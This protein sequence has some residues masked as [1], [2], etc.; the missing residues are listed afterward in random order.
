MYK[1]TGPTPTYRAARS[2]PAQRTPLERRSEGLAL[3]RVVQQ[4]LAAGLDEEATYALVGGRLRDSFDAQTHVLEE[5][6]RFQLALLPRRLPDLPHVEIAAHMRPAA[7]VSGGYYDFFVADGDALTFAV[8]DAPGHGMRAAGMVA[9]VKSLLAGYHAGPDLLEIMRQSTSA[10]R[11]IASPGRSMA[12]ALGRVEGH[13]LELVGTGMPSAL[14]QQAATG[15]VEELPFDGSQPDG[16]QAGSHAVHRLALCPGDTIV[17]MSDGFTGLVNRDGEVLGQH[18]AVTLLEATDGLAPDEVV[19][20]L[21]HLVQE[22]T[23]GQALRDDVVL[24]VLQA[25]AVAGAAP[26]SDGDARPAVMC[27]SGVA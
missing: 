18:R 9:A 13:L 24:V 3:I 27:R 8:G 21:V 1:A 4:A 12:L 6:R 19:G 25:R 23:H 15:L 5:A 17:L 7:E 16:A 2:N 22:W 11:Q 10:L 20:R 14:V 26:A